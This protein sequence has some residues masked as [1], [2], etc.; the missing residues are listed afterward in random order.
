MKIS[1][2][3]GM[4]SSSCFNYYRKHTFTQL[5]QTCQ[6]S[7]IV[8]CARNENW[9]QQQL[10]T[11]IIETS[12]VFSAFLPQTFIWT[13]FPRF[14][15]ESVKYCRNMDWTRPSRPLLD[16]LLTFYIRWNELYQNAFHGLIYFRPFDN[17]PGESSTPSDL[18]V[19]KK[20]IDTLM[21]VYAM[22]SPR[23]D[24]FPSI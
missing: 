7:D 12:P 3:L 15:I 16:T 2:P 21:E 24:L 13:Q 11:C 14:L 10:H 23:T 17:S 20:F 22:E 6:N 4:Q 9:N 5:R 8:N 19:I 18:Y 1:S